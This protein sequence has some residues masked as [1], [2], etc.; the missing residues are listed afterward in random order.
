MSWNETVPSIQTP[1]VRPVWSPF[2][3]SRD[4]STGSEVVLAAGDRSVTAFFMGQKASTGH[5]VMRSQRRQTLVE[6]PPP[7]DKVSYR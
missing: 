2:V 1:R 7:S 5:H 4:R 3:F 6:Q